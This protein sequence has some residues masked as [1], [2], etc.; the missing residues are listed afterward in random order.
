MTPR[1]GGKG[2]LIGADTREGLTS[3]AASLSDEH[4][5]SFFEVGDVAEV[6]RVVPISKVLLK[7]SV[8]ASCKV[9]HVVDHGEKS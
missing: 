7:R 3:W 2:H 8:P 9:P 6:E 5:S 4:R 1:P